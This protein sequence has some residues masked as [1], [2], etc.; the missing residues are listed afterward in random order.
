M[1]KT[2]KE[3]VASLREVSLLSGSPV[4]QKNGQWEIAS[5]KETWEAIGPRLFDEHLDKFKAVSIE[6][7][8]ERDPKFELEKDQRFAANIYGK[9]LRHSH[10]LR[11]GLSETLALLGCF[12]DALTSCTQG[13]AIYVADM[14]VHEILKDGDW[15]LWASLNDLLPTLAEAAP[16]PFLDSVTK[17]LSQTPCPFVAVYSQEGPSVM[18]QNYLTGLLWALETL[19]WHGDYLQ[20]VTVLLGEL[21]AIDPGGNWANRPSNS[22]TDIFLPWFPQT[23]ASIPKR[24]SAITALIKEQPDVA[25]KM[26]VS[27]LPSGHSSSMGCRKPKWRNFILP[28]WSDKITN[29]EYWEQVKIYA[30]MLVDMAIKD[31]AKLPE[32]VDQISHLPNPAHSRALEHISSKI[33]LE[34]PEESRLPLWEKL[35]ALIVKHRR[36]SS[37]QWAMPPE[38]ITKIEEAAAKLAPKTASLVYHRLFS[39]YEHEL[40]EELEDYDEQRKKIWEHR[41]AA[42]R[43]ILSVGTMSGLLDFARS[44]K[45]PEAVGQA[46]GGIEYELADAELLPGLLDTED[47]T[48]SSFIGGFVFGRYWFKGW[49]WVD[50]IITDKWTTS[51]K[52]K[53]FTLLPFVQGAWQRA[54]SS[55]GN[56]QAEYWS[57]VRVHP[58]GQKDEMLEVAEKLLNFGRPGAALSCLYGLVLGKENILFPPKLAV[59]A[60]MDSL[61]TTEKFGR[62]DAHE[63]SEVIKWLQNNPETN[64]DDLFQI[65]WAYLP[66]LDH[67]YGGEPKTIEARMASDPS[68]F[69]EVIGVVFR[70]DKKEQ[71]ETKPTEQE[72]NIATNAYRLLHGWRTVPGKDSKGVFDS[73][74]FKKWLAEVVQKTKESGHY[75]ISLNQIGQV[76]PYAP[77]DPDGLWIHH[78][79]AE[80]LNAKDADEMRSGFTMDLFNQRG[81]HGFSKGEDERKL[82]ADFSN[83]ADA[84]EERGYQRIATAVRELAKGYERDAEREAKRNP[85]GE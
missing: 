85:Y 55:L 18:G 84:L 49:A 32:L 80:A 34:L 31:T 38:A 81:V 14:A 52:A 43:E 9:A 63:I 27:L 73:E 33:V 56:D 82:A 26:I 2:E 1:I 76:L 11:K 58:F 17:A 8:R 57:N 3:L 66:L 61:N 6:V 42:V 51:H 70:S 20:R 59:R 4:K 45:F 22:L 19:A 77:Q 12:P 39:E 10:T 37:A 13:K 83:K 30:E 47:N 48:L 21:A 68:F 75:R 35:T 54:E 69:C 36:F 5:R 23:C 25:W 53:F 78:V 71:A 62:R 79:V 28:D 7:L 46:L 44:V 41:Q 50:S 67:D 24:R 60:L 64:P 16:V 72:Q 29:G 15:V 74:L 40:F 65:E